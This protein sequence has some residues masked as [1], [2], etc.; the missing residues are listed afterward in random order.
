MKIGVD[1]RCLEWHRGGVARYLVNMLK[2]WPQ[3]SERHR[4]VLYWQNHVPDDAFL[5]NPV[6]EHRL[7]RGPWFLRTSRILT[8]QLLMPLPIACDK[9]DL[10]F[11]T[12]Y[13]APLL[14]ACPRTVVAAWDISY[15][16][17]P[18]HYSLTNR[19]SLG[20]FS[21][22]ACRRAAGV[23]TCSPFDA[24]QIEKHYGIPADRICT[25]EL[26][27]D[28][29]FR[30][31]Q[32]GHALNVVLKKYGLPARYLLSLG[33]IYNR[34]SVDVL[35]AAFKDIQDQYPDA[36][37]FVVGRNVTEPR[38]DIQGMM[39]PLIEAGRGAYVERIPDDELPLLY[40]GAW[41][42]ICTSTVDGES[43][44]LKEAMRCGTPVIT[45]PLI[46][47]SVRGHALIIKDPRSRQETAAMLRR[48][49]ESV[50]LRARH[51]DEGLRWVRT[52]SWERVARESLEFLKSR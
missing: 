44:M 39:R 43:I 35:I 36:G 30:P 48:A 22:K 10:F 46:E 17:H 14:C 49:F 11:A 52:L 20:F 33:V 50:D 18:S 51:A 19:V 7:V 21:R 41:Y 16:T 37:L 2:L 1:A 47:D 13:S 29:M 8:E 3:L 4:F 12:W 32:N 38:M 42:Y 6:F 40:A 5:T 27:P 23:I 34:R 24:R 31:G 25:L 28:D 26:A 45:S 15:T 9:L